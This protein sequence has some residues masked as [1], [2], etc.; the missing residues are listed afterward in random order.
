MPSHGVTTMVAERKTKAEKVKFAAQ[1]TQLASEEQGPEHRAAE[2]EEQENVPRPTMER[3]LGLGAHPVTRLPLSSELSAP[4]WCLQAR[5]STWTP[6]LELSTTLGGAFSPEAGEAR[7][8][9]GETEEQ[10]VT[11][12]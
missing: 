8:H 11:Q 2:S 4:G 10:E 12:H 6:V 7:L 3:P 9:R 1:S 5:G